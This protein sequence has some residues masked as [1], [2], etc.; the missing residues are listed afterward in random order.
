MIQGLLERMAGYP[1]LFLFCALSGIAFPLPED[2]SLLYAGSRI[3]AGQ[4][5]WGPVLLTAFFGVMVRDVLAWSTGRVLGDWLLETTLVRRM[6]G[7]RRIERARSMVEERGSGAVLAGR[8]L[9]GLRAPIFLVAGAMGVSFRRFVV[10]NALG[11]L[12]AVPATLA[13]GAVFGE[14][15]AEGAFWVARQGRLGFVGLGATLAALALW[16]WRSLRTEEDDLEDA[17]GYTEDAEEG[18]ISG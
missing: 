13:L 8:F 1:G 16:R 11:L 7:R 17:E 12:V 10:W 3:Q 9:V 6:I 14:P 18:R 15:L 2:V 4:M 5:A